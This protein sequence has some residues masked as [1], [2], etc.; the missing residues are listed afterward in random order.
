MHVGSRE[1]QRP[2]PTA[3]RGRM[4]QAVAL[5][6][7]EWAR[8]GRVET[9]FL[10]GSCVWCG[11]SIRSFLATRPAGGLRPF[12]WLEGAPATEANSAAQA[13]VAG[14]RPPGGRVGPLGPYRDPVSSG[15]L[16]LV[17]GLDTLVPRYSTSGWVATLPLA[18]GSA[19]D[20]SQQRRAGGCRRLPPSRWS[21]RPARAVSRPGF[22]RGAVSGAGSRYARSSLLDQRVGCDP[23]VGSR[24]RQRPKPTAPRGRMSQAVALAVV[25]WARSGRVETRFLAGSCV[26]CGVSIR[27]FLATRPAG[28][29]RP[30]RW[31]EGAPATEANSAARADVAGCRPRGGRVGPLGPCRDPVAGGELCLVRG[32]DTLVPRYSTSGCG[33][34]RR[35]FRRAQ[36]AA[37]VQMHVG[38]R[39]RQRPKPTT[40]RA[41]SRGWRC[42][43]GFRWLPPSRWSS[44]PARAVSRP[45]FWRGAVSGAGSRY[46]RSSLLDQRVWRDVGAGATRARGPPPRTPRSGQHPSGRG[47]S[48]HRWTRRPRRARPQSP[49]RRARPAAPEHCRG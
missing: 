8:S 5:A 21:S 28:G 4:S 14:C 27:S 46:A 39:E 10:A 26:W 9:R 1:R 25:E 44:R 20:R 30:F 42:A 48:R 23:S 36:S 37:A 12:R 45:G 31:L 15:E 29:L 32:L 6:V 24:E 17:R 18:R 13:D 43:G 35:G 3:P 16:C 34:A 41:R 49:L 2:K 40:P 19:S 47:C 33:A 22:Q 7:V 11:V 38:S